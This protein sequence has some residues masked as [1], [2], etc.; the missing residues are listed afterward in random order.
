MGG[1]S[2]N[3]VGTEEIKAIAIGIL[4][5]GVLVPI[6]M[7]QWLSYTPV[8]ATVAAIWITGAVLAVVGLAIKFLI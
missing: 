5:A 7:G 8:N 3:L 1:E 4:L 6:G 2:K